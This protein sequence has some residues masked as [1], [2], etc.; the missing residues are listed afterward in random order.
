[1]TQEVHLTTGLIEIARVGGN[2]T[3]RYVGV[4]TVSEEA[5]DEI[6]KATTH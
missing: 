5:H 4:P 6:R 2:V 1:M 3:L